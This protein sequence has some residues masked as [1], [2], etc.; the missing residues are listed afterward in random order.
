MKLIVDGEPYEV[1]GVLRYAT[2]G[3]MDDLHEQS[4]GAVTIP[5][6]EDTFTRLSRDESTDRDLRADRDFIRSVAGLVFL[7]KRSAGVECTWDDARRQKYT[8]IRFEVE[9]DEESPKDP[10]GDVDPEAD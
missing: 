6:I 1:R 9:V 8:E 5:F 7:A 4:G 2:L 10:E 3:D